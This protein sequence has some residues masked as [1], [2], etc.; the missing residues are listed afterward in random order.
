M[1]IDRR[2]FLGSVLSSS[3][4]VHLPASARSLGATVPGY[5]NAH[6]AAH[7]PGQGAAMIFG[8]ADEG[9]VLNT[10]WRYSRNRWSLL[11]RSGPTPR[12]F[13]ALAWDSHRRRLVLFGGNRV[14]FGTGGDTVLDDHW[15][16][17]GRGWARSTGPRPPG[18]TEACCAFDPVRKRT[19]LFGGWRYEDGERVRLGDLWE[20]D[21]AAWTRVAARGPEPRS[22]AAMTWDPLHKRMLMG[23]GN[24][25]RSDLWAFDGAGWTRLPD[26]PQPRF[27]PVLAFDRRR[28]QALLFGGWTGRER[29]AETAR[30]DGASWRAHRGLQPSPRNHTILIPAGDGSRLLLVGGHYGDEV[31]ADVWEWTGRWRML[32]AAPPRARTPNDH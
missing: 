25:P 2:S 7:D 9:R 8:G 20:W 26:L 6:S 16:W 19:L 28:R 4:I 24:G 1:S 23:G 29:L 22:G 15:E 17:D 21:G 32:H 10:L 13:A 18:R 3:L 31:L 11:S 5:L 30:F 27:N 14:L 12:T